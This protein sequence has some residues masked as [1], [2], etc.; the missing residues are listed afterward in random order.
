MKLALSLV[1]QGHKLIYDPAVHI[2]HMEGA[3]PSEEHRHD[4]NAASHKDAVFNQ[5]LTVLEYLKTQKLGRI[6]Q[7][8]YLSYLTIRGTRWAPGILMLGVCLATRYPHPWKRF[9]ATWAAIF[10]GMMAAR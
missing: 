2:D 5:T 10:E 6:R 1:A 9:K 8:A 7:L 4:F 3:R